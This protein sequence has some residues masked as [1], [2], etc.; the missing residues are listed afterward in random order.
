MSRDEFESLRRALDDCCKSLD[1]Q[2]RRIAQ[3]QAELD[4]IRGAWMRGLKGST[5][6]K[7]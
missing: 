6:K 1:I 7:R 5:K 4:E 3:I 2:F